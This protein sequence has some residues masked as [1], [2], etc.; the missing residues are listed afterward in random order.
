LGAAHFPFT[1]RDPDAHTVAQASPTAGNGPVVHV[2]ETQWPAPHAR[3]LVQAPP[4][5]IAGT[6]RRWL[7]EPLHSGCARS[8][9]SCRVKTASMSF[10][11][12]H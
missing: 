4:G 11:T 3:S 10:A 8:T 6:Q 5:A 1:H 2:P 9:P 12:L 7:Q